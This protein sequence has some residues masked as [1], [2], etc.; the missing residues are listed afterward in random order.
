MGFSREAFLCEG[1]VDA[2]GNQFDHLVQ[3]LILLAQIVGLLFAHWGV[4]R[5]HDADDPDLTLA[6]CVSDG[7]QRQV[8]LCQVCLP[9]GVADFNAGSR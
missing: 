4:E 7:D 1:G 6:L 8:R 2:H 5:R 3:A 9:Q